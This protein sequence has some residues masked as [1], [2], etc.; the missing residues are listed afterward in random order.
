MSCVKAVGCWVTMVGS[1]VGCGFVVAW[2]VRV[3]TLN[4][5]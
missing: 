4:G 3:V 1:V 2:V 5:W